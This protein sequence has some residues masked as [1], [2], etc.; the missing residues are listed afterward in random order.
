MTTTAPPRSF[1]LTLALIVAL[2]SFAIDMYLASLPAIVDEFGA[3]PSLIQWTLTGYLLVLGAGQLI[4]GP[5]TDTVGRRRPL[6]VGLMLFTAGSL[7]AA[8]APTA[9]ALV[10]ARVLQATGGAVA[11]VVANSSVRDRAQG[12]TAT[13][14]YAL[15]LMISAVAPVMAP[16]VGG[17]IEEFFGWRSVFIA[18]TG[19]GIMAIIATVRLLPES[20]PAAGRVSLRFGYVLRGYT[21]TLAADHLR[22][23]WPRSRQSACSGSPTSVGQPT[24][25]RAHTDWVR[26]SSGCSSG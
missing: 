9:W 10:I 23:P 8:V 5:V 14:L 12:E 20:L 26:P 11:V 24:F 16:S 25:T 13:R 17:V 7:M 19:V 15:L 1:T 22:G 6:L 21:T 4:A 18:L 2:G 3:S